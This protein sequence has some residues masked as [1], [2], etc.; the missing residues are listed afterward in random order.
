ML[1]EKAHSGTR[2]RITVGESVLAGRVG[3][4]ESHLFWFHIDGLPGTIKSF[5]RSKWDFTPDPVTLPTEDGLYIIEPSRDE[6][7]TVWQRVRG[8]WHQGQTKVPDDHVE[9]ALSQGE[10]IVRLTREDGV[11]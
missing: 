9:R 11:K 6:T 1:I 10:R 7:V 4:V 3:A 2:G 8:Q 5:A